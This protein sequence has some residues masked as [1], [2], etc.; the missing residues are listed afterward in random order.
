MIVDKLVNDIV[1]EA[2]NSAEVSVSGGSDTEASRPDA[3]KKDDKGHSRTSSTKKPATF[4]SVSVN[5][6]FLAAKAASSTGAPKVGEKPTTPVSSAATPTSA[7]AT[8][9]P[10]L[11]AKS[12]GILRDASKSSLTQNGRPAPDGNAVW[13]KNRRAF[14]LP[15]RSKRVGFPIGMSK[16]TL[17]KLYAA[18][19]PPDPKK[20]TDEELAKIGIHMANRLHPDTTKGQST[21]ADIDD[22][23]ED[24]AAPE[25]ITW[26]DGTKTTIPHVDETANTPEQSVVKEV[27][28]IEK[29]RSPAPPLPPAAPSGSP[30]VKPGG[31]ASGKG[32]VLKSA[33][34]EKPTLVAK[35]PAPPTPVKSPWAPLPPMPK[36][37]PM[38]VPHEQPLRGFPPSHAY[39]PR[40]SMP[41][42]AREIAPD[43]FSRS[44][45]RDNQ[46][47]FNSQSGRYEPVPDRRGMARTD[48]HPRQPAVLQRPMHPE[49]QGPAEPSAAFQTTHTSGGYGRRR[50]SSNVSGGSGSFARPNRP[51]DQ[52]MGPP[53]TL[54]ARRPSF[55]T[56]V[57]DHPMSPETFSPSV[58]AGNSG[59]PAQGAQGGPTRQPGTSPWQARAS[60]AMSTA[61]PHIPGANDIPAVPG[62]GVLPTD[63]AV[64]TVEYQKRLMKERR[65][66]AIRRRQ[67][68][69]AKE[70]AEK[71]ERLAKK[72]EAMGPPPERK[73]AKKDTEKEASPSPAGQ[74]NE[75]PETDASQ[76]ATTTKPSTDAVPAT[77]DASQNSL[78]NGLS[79]A[80]QPQHPAP[81]AADPLPTGENRHGH[82]W[83]PRLP[84]QPERIWG[85]GS[86]S[87]RNVWGSPNDRSLGNGTFNSVPDTQPPQIAS[88][89]GGRPAPGPIGP[90][91]ATG[92][93]GPA[94]PS[95]RLGPIGPPQRNGP[96]PAAD[97]DKEKR[98]N[99]WAQVVQEDDEE[100][101][102]EQRTRM[103]EQERDMKARGLSYS[104]LAM[105]IQDQWTETN[106][107]GHSIR[108]EHATYGGSSQTTNPWPVASGG[109]QDERQRVV[110][111][112][113]AGHHGA[114]GAVSQQ[115]RFFPPSRDS[116]HPTGPDTGRPKSPSPPPPEE[117]GIH[118]AFDGDAAHPHVSLPKTKPIVKLPPA[119]ASVSASQRLGQQTSTWGQPSPFRDGGVTHAH[120][121]RSQFSSSGSFS[122]GTNAQ[123]VDRIK[124][125]FADK[126]SS[127]NSSSRTA[128]PQPTY[129]TSAT[130]S[131]PGIYAPSTI[132]DDGSF[133]TKTMDEDCFEEQEMGSLPPVH[134]PTDVPDAAWAPAKFPPRQDR[135]LLPVAPTTV[136]TLTFLQEGRNVYIQLPNNTQGRKTVVMTARSSGNRGRGSRGGLRYGSSYRG[137]NR[138]R[139][140]SASYSPEQSSTSSPA[141]G[142]GGRG[143]RGRASDNWGRSAPTTAIHTQ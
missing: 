139:D 73:S 125:L 43:D 61:A 74:S 99:R 118:P 56:S 113:S 119:P 9:K 6:T 131:L 95:S 122:Q 124:N 133:V 23:D 127:V 25:A 20:F 16:L 67:E 42:T 10:R 109:R 90:P 89:P 4:K 32:L 59:H 114:A 92:A 104:D 65:E 62:P 5:K 21:W 81:A 30:S 37:S 115:S 46:Q 76:S 53:D 106:E 77:K 8:P 55:T 15:L 84:D 18:V 91:R 79:P 44:P 38:D 60:P 35:P 123:I 26:T 143:H 103:L 24:W 45:R 58:L 63:N 116:Q 137:G 7:S 12:G 108:R 17:L 136:E 96:R 105:P 85:P 86:Q 141:P 41:P 70:E 71:R 120:P 102:I 83:Q 36:V 31:L 64:E 72:L 33:S 100:R 135:K 69:E 112:Q 13:N 129:A 11:V 128:M 49:S 82:P 48:Y 51:Y 110:S 14:I 3:S 87:S 140:T 68:L 138:G 47:L 121:L 132:V 66:A 130:V 29:P 101:R 1:D 40:A 117:D 88:I 107:D 98:R 94:G 19:P 50:G 75:T 111:S 22:D 78:A 97:D 126:P 93:T 80:S 2:I 27:K 39:G 134:L 34:S 28:P 57:G 142:R 52:S 54:N